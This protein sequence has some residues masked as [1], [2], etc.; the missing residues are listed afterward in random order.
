MN[1]LSRTIAR[2]RSTARPHAR[3]ALTRWRPSL[4]VLEDRLV[5]STASMITANFNGTAIPAGASIWFNAAVT[6]TGLPKGAPATVHVVNE[7]IDFTAAGKAYHVPVPNGIIVFTPRATS[8]AATYDPGDNDWDISAPSSGAGDVFMT[9]VA[10]KTATALPGGIKNV[11][12]SASFW[13]DT[14]GLTVNWKWAAA[15]YNGFG[16]D[17]TTLGVKPVDNNTLSVYKNSDDSGTPEAFKTHVIAGALGG[18]GTNYTGNATKT[19]GVK[20]ALGDGLQDYPFPSSNPRTSVAFNESTVVKAAAMDLV[21]GTFQVWYSD[22]HA[23]A[24][25]VRQVNVKTASGTTTTN[26]PITT[27]AP[28]VN[29][30]VALN[31]KVGTTATSG[32]QAGT[33]LSNR[34]IAPSLFIT[35]ITVDANNRSGDWQYGGTA[36]PP[37]AVFG[38][39][40]SAVRTVDATSSPAVT[41]VTCDVDPAK[42]N[43]NLG[44]GSDAPPAGTPTEGYG[45]EVR[46]SLSDL[47]NQGYLVPGHTYR[48]YVII[49]DG[50]QNKS[51]GDCGQ[52]SFNYAYPGPAIQPVSI[53]GHVNSNQGVMAGV[54]ITL[55]GKDVYGVTVL[56]TAVT[57]ASGYYH[58]DT[59]NPGDYTLTAG[60]L[61]GY[62]NTSATAGTV[63]GLKKGTDGV[64][65]IASIHLVSADIGINYD[66]LES[67]G[68]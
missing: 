20:P 39:W 35:D 1:W 11:T 24:L 16:T 43:W 41:T 2:F 58:F 60:T 21:K 30:D 19:V 10:L 12:W 51:G 3:K 56:V 17:N 50:D 64:A 23:L 8:A 33:D 32:N 34:P 4:D 48:F 28:N 25:G 47:Q 63:K 55:A 36:L 13:S 27:M 29:P 68:E 45:A 18:G 14:A 66:F 61:P 57:D 31:A 7:A 26:Y 15:V 6:A 37:G 52:A 40:K 42:N 44:P 54:T 5:P 9:G 49:H 38:T 65:T 53:S 59:F 46:W 62:A 22:E 67:F